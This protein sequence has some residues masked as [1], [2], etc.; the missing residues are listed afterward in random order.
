MFAFY[1]SIGTAVVANVFYH[2]AMKQT[3]ERLIDS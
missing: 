2:V 1:G 3:S